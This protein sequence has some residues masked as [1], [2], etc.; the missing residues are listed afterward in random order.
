MPVALVT[1]A[2][3][4]IGLE[5]VKQLEAKGFKVIGTSRKELEVS[6]PDSIKAFSP[7]DKIDLLINNAGLLSREETP[8]KIVD[9]FKVN[10]LGPF[11]VFQ[12]LLPNLNPN[13]KIINITSRM[14]SIQ[15]NTSGGYYGYRASKAALNMITKSLA[16]DN[17][18]FVFLALHPGFVKTDMTGN[19]GECDPKESVEKMLLVV[20]KVGKEESGQFWHRDGYV[21]P[22]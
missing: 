7:T 12:Q 18:Q 14:G 6:N 3:R 11:L 16:I 8:S 22:N 15:D 10:A 19:N 17:P 9:Q 13:A 5:F 21:L 20:D 4:G 2:N 1:G